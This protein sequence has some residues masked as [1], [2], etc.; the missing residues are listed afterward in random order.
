MAE[1]Y[2]GMPAMIFDELYR[3]GNEW[4]FAASGQGTKDTS[5]KQLCKHFM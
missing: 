1:N 4:K 3:D 2:S 5:I